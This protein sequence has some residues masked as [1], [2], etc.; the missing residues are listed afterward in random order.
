MLIVIPSSRS[1]SLE[2]LQ[3]IIDFGARFIIVDDSE[4]SIKIDHPQFTVYTWKDQDS[5]LVAT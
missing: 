1:V 3:P 2:Y 4:S 5:I